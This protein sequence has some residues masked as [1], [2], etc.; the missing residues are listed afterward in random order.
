M[1]PLPS[2]LPRSGGRRVE[3]WTLPSNVPLLMCSQYQPI[4]KDHSSI[5]TNK[6]TFLAGKTKLSLFLSWTGSEPYSTEHFKVENNAK[7]I[8]PYR[9]GGGRNKRSNLFILRS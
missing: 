9:E 2:L 8:N 6:G 5:S 1:H 7:K 4:S 3:N